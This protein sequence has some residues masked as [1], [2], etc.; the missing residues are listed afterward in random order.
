MKFT[1]LSCT[2]AQGP[3]GLPG[4]PS[5]RDC[6]NIKTATE[7]KDEPAITDPMA[8]P[9]EVLADY[10]GHL[11][12]CNGGVYVHRDS[13]TTQGVNGYTHLPPSGHEEDVYL[14]C[15]GGKFV[16]RVRFE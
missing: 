6:E 15:A 4:A 12:Y 13:P 3:R 10:R 11:L 2:P 14:S 16:A 8:Q 7:G 5:V 1:V 9:I